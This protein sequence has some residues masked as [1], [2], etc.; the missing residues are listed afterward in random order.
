VVLTLVGRSNFLSF[1]HRE[2]GW[3][4]CAEAAVWSQVIVV[5]TPRFD[6]FAS[7]GES[8]EHVLIEAL[9]PQAAVERFDEGV[10]HRFAGFD[11]VPL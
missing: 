6:G 11:V 9:V 4:Q 3:S 2:L 8:E 7:L 1:K 5:V 10:L